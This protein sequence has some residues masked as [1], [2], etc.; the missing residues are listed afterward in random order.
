MG[1][2]QE[3]IKIGNREFPR[4][5]GG[6]L[7]GIT[8]S[9]FRALVRDFSK[10]EL[11]YTEMR[12]VACVAN[13]KGSQKALLFEQLERP[14]NYQVSANTT[15]FIEQACEKILQ[16][17]VDAIDLNIGCPAK[18]VVNSGSGSA[19]MADIPRLK[20]I[21]TLFRKVIPIPFTVKIRAGF[22]QCNAV[23]VAKV[24]QDC[25][26]D[27]IAIHPRL[28]TQK[29]E[30]RPNYA[31]AAEVKQAVQIPIIISGGVVNFKTAQLVY[32]QT[33]V[34]GFLIGRGIWARPWKLHE[35][36]EHAGG[37]LY[38]ANDQIVITYALKHLDNLISYY[39]DRGLYMFRKHLPFYLRSLPGAAALRQRLVVTQSIDEVRQELARLLG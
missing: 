26:V 6:P 18:N 29:F 11:L 4:F 16:A 10:E 21:V 33:G 19:L 35:L 32:E 2:W 37:D 20:E 12:H 13:D 17:G 38:Q 7:D 39:G 34:D 27:A 14:L 9:P 36:I 30:G 1:F 5:I 28:Q 25:G 8:D 31:V 15:K 22:K 24:L 23:E 3:K